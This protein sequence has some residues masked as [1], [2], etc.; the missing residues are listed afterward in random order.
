[1]FK[2]SGEPQNIWKEVAFD[3]VHLWAEDGQ[4]TQ[5]EIVGEPVNVAF[6]SGVSP[7]VVTLKAEHV[8]NTPL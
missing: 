7:E 6:I 8:T 2:V 3:I 1:M 5:R 4:Y